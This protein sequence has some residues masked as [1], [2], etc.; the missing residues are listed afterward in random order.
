MKFVGFDTIDIIIGVHLALP[1]W[2]MNLSGAV[3]R[4]LPLTIF[5]YLK[6]EKSL[7]LLY[8]PLTTSSSLAC[9]VSSALLAVHTN[10]TGSL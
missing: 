2:S 8:S 6:Y 9:A 4:L 1:A 7:V 5:F 3:S 10:P